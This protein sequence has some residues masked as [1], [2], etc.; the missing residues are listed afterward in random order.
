MDGTTFIFSL[1]K[2]DENADEFPLITIEVVSNVVRQIKGKFNRLPNEMENN[3]IR[4]WAQEKH[5]KIAC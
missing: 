3:I 5:L 4:S 2:I 1:R